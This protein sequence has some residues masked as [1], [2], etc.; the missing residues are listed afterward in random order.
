[1]GVIAG[2]AGDT[3]KAAFGEP[4]PNKITSK[5][6]ITRT[7]ATSSRRRSMEGGISLSYREE[8][9]LVS[10]SASYSIVDAILTSPYCHQS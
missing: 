7:A 1:V 9:T 3:F 2:V 8:P 6:T 4:Q 5:T 10:V